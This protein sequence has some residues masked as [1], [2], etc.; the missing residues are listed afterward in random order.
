[1]GYEQH[2]RAVSNCG[3]RNEGKDQRQE[4][5]AAG[6]SGR[7]GLAERGAEQEK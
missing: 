6:E 4:Y 5:A 7:Q 1:M 2:G 3:F